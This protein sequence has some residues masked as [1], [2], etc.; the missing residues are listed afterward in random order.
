MAR[1]FAV[2]EKLKGVRPSKVDDEQERYAQTLF[3]YALDM[4][5]GIEG[6]TSVLRAAMAVGITN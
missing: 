5:H 6:A 3:N 2:A 1:A 4:G